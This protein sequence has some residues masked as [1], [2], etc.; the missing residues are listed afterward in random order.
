MLLPKTLKKSLGRFLCRVGF[1]RFA[2]GSDYRFC[3][4]CG[5]LQ[6]A[7]ARFSEEV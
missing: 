5:L 2:R 7:R 4:R 1:H 3:L 6:R